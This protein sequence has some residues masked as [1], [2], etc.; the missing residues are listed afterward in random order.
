ME[1]GYVLD[2]RYEI[3]ELIG[4]GGHG[5][6]YRALDRELSQ[7]VAI[8]VLYG[9]VAAEREF[10][11]RMQREARAMGALAGTNAVQVMAFNATE[12]GALYLVMEFLQGHDLGDYLTEVEKSGRPLPLSEVY[13]IL[14]PVAHTLQAAH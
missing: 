14:E 1:V 5:K 3:R 10:R 9:E 7:P 8:K 11:V 13:E 2:D 6:V 12:W 4:K